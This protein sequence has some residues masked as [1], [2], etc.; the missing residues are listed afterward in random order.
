MAIIQPYLGI[1]QIKLKETD[2][3]TIEDTG[4]ALTRYS[5]EY[6]YDANLNSTLL[7]AQDFVIEDDYTHLVFSFSVI[8]EQNDYDFFPTFS[9]LAVQGSCFDRWGG[10]SINNNIEKTINIP[11]D[12]FENDDIIFAKEWKDG[13][14]IGRIFVPKTY[15][16]EIAKIKSVFIAMADYRFIHTNTPKDPN[17]PHLVAGR[18]FNFEEDSNLSEQNPLEEFAGFNATGKITDVTQL[19]HIT[20]YQE[21][22]YEPSDITDLEGHHIAIAPVSITSKDAPSVYGMGKTAFQSDTYFYSKIK[23]VFKKISDKLAPSYVLRDDSLDQNPDWRFY[24]LE[25]ATEL[26]IF[27]DPRFQI[28]PQITVQY[29]HYLYTFESNPLYP[30]TSFLDH[31]KKEETFFKYFNFEGERYRTKF[32]SHNVKEQIINLKSGVLYGTC[33]IKE[34]SGCPFEF[35]KVTFPQAGG[36]GYNYTISLSIDSETPIQIKCTDTTL[37]GDD[38]ISRR[39]K[40]ISMINKFTGESTNQWFY[41]PLLDE[42][43]YYHM[44]H[45]I[46]LEQKQLEQ[47]QLEQKTKYSENLAGQQEIVKYYD[48][49]LIDNIRDSYVID[50]NPNLENTNPPAII[51]CNIGLTYFDSKKPNEVTNSSDITN[52][53]SYFRYNTFSVKTPDG[54]IDLTDKTCFWNKDKGYT[55]V[56]CRDFSNIVKDNFD[57][58]KIQDG[59]L[60]Y[61]IKTAGIGDYNNEFSINQFINY[62]IGGNHA[63]GLSG[64]K[65]DE[66]FQIYDNSISTE[67]PIIE[68]RSNSTTPYTELLKLLYTDVTNY[69]PFPIGTRTGA[70]IDLTIKYIKPL[71]VTVQTTE[72]QN[73]E[74]QNTGDYYYTIFQATLT[75]IPIVTGTRPLA[76]RRG[77]IIV[78]P[79]D[80]NEILE[81]DTSVKINLKT[82]REKDNKVVGK[83]IN[84][85]LCDEVG[86]PLN[87]QGCSI[88]YR[89]THDQN[90]DIT[91]GSFY[92]DNVN[93]SALKQQTET[94]TNIISNNT[95]NIAEN[96]EMIRLIIAAF[97]GY[98][99]SLQA[100]TSQGYDTYKIGTVS[101]VSDTK[102]I[103]F[104]N[105]PNNAL[106]VTNIGRKILSGNTSKLDEE[107]YSLSYSEKRENNSYSVTY[108]VSYRQRNISDNS[109]QFQIE[110]WL[111]MAIPPSIS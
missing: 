64:S 93:L 44:G 49:S 89:G 50:I 91:S 67:E 80:Q 69:L 45:Q 95:T 43:R 92:F 76:F 34:G 79:S 87:E 41:V 51:E 108:T 48:C 3:P 28:T 6:P 10:Q 54:S 70:T 101:T 111:A 84:I 13:Y 16:Q 62:C 71:W 86:N 46:W 109:C 78:N 27:I 99:L 29:G 57:T 66:I 42:Y 5:P 25:Q 105:I 18:Y 7:T 33:Q 106:I 68:L 73:T 77:G 94:N 98:T 12:D 60:I 31:I 85:N 4:V 102:T 65:R 15:L 72:N 38:F 110:I 96:T 32:V 26:E 63:I 97:E 2:S 8:E 61:K 53:E 59:K 56:Y 17:N 58:L 39:G 47:E 21:I 24:P 36:E 83:A 82:V 30:Y 88:E 100:K 9:F 14:A 55:V 74:G 23:Y 52:L 19:Y 22:P 90:G 20:K 37:Y 104:D 81:K 103:T 107:G 11:I 1:T 40:Q 35:S 75:E